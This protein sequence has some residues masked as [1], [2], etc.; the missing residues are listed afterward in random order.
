M[1]KLISFVVPIY[2]VEK[3]LEKCV[4][5]ICSN[6]NNE[7]SEVILVDDGSTDGSLEIAK[8]LQKNNDIIKVFHKE[9]GGLSDARNYGIKKANGKYICFIDSDDFIDGDFKNVYKYLN[10]DYEV[11][12]CGYKAVYLKEIKEIN[13]D[14]QGLVEDNIINNVLEI[15]SKKN[16]AWSKIVKRDFLIKNNLFF[17]KGFAED[18]NW[19]GRAI[20][21][22]KKAYISNL[23]YYNYIVERENSLMNTY[24]KQKFIDVI[25][26]AKDIIEALN[27]NSLTKVE[28]KKIRQ[29]VGFNVVSNFRFVKYLSKN[30]EK[31]ELY[32]LLK[33]NFDLVKNQENFML[34]TFVIIGKIFGFKFAYRFV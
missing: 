16:S 5:S 32:K 1:E 15:S 26:Q 7:N 21:Y 8:K 25:S 19:I 23:C 29:F 31:V 24:K 12:F 2:N 18:F 27:K 6:C 4:N 34:K 14:K 11:I 3:Y 28:N 30:E 10:S 9:N 33:T 13:Y 17:K 22:I 20:Q